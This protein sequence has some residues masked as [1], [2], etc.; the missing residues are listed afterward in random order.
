VRI[1]ES[2]RVLAV[3]KGR[4]SA[5]LGGPQRRLTRGPECA[6]ARFAAFLLLLLAALP[7]W[8]AEK[9]RLHVDDY[10]ID[11]TIALISLRRAPKSSSRP[12]KILR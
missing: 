3:K 1:I 8:G 6:P 10:A 4:N 11:A 5:V 2:K 7:G 9:P 12:W